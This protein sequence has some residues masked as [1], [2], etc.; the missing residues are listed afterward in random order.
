MFL[1]MLFSYFRTEEIMRGI[2]ITKKGRMDRA[3]EGFVDIFVNGTTAGKNGA[4]KGKGK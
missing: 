3:V 2:D 1:G 4:L